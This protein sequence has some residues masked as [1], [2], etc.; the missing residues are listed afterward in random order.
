MSYSRWSNSRWYTYGSRQGF[1][2]QS[3]HIFGDSFIFT[4][5]ELKK[6]LEGCAK[7]VQQKTKCS[8]EEKEELKIYMREYLEDQ[9]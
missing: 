2:I 6:D 5:K 3:F 9:I 7:K 1:N 8:N 4:E